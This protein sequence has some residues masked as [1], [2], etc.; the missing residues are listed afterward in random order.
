MK[1]WPRRILN[2][3]LFL[4][5]GLMVLVFLLVAFGREFSRRYYLEQQVKSLRSN[6]E[7][8]EGKNQEFGRLIEYFNTQNFTEEEARLKMGYK[9]IGEEVLVIN[10]PEIKPKKSEEEN[11]A[12]ISNPAKWWLYFFKNLNNNNN[13]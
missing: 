1:P 2:S 5:F 3:K 11:L 4:A 13:S 7:E 6:I 8:L 12:T 9:K 10:Q